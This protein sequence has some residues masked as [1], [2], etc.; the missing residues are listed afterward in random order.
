MREEGE[1]GRREVR[2]KKEGRKEREREKDVEL[3]L[4]K[5]EKDKFQTKISLSR[6]EA[7]LQS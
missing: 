1:K 6:A 5:W 2:R 7:P 4:L 3:L